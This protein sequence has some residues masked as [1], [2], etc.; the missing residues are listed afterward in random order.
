MKIFDSTLSFALDYRSKEFSIILLILGDKKPQVESWEPF[1]KNRADEEQIR[2]WFSDAKT[3]IGILTG[4]ISCIVGFDID[5]C[6]AK[7]CFDQLI[8]RIADENITIVV[9]NTMK[10]MT[11]SGN[12][13]V[14]LG[15]K[16]KEFSDDSKETK[17]TVLWSSKDAHSEIRL[18]GE[19]GYIVAPPSIHPN[20]KPYE[21]VNGNS[22]SVITKEQLQKLIAE[23]KNI[24]NN[25]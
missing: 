17:S 18:K 23:F 16:P 4:K 20:G 8:V 15:I 6:K 11:G 19:G 24:R 13:N 3:N 25:V 2:K 7:K 21:F 5:G 22:I 1:K 12:V 9:K 10:I 14:V